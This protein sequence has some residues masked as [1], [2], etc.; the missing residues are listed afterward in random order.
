MSSVYTRTIWPPRW[1]GTN[2]INYWPSLLSL[3]CIRPWVLS[4]FL[5]LRGP[6]V[7]KKWRAS[8][9][10]AP[11]PCC[12]S[13]IRANFVGSLS[14][15]ENFSSIYFIPCRLLMLDLFVDT[16]FHFL[17]VFVSVWCNFTAFVR[18]KSDDVRVELTIR[19]NDLWEAWSH[20]CSWPIWRLS[21][22]LFLHTL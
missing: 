8:A 3:R 18:H 15:L 17:H 5:I 19:G 14:L 16:Y 11:F 12:A 13:G 22:L 10:K 7:A 20:S 4:L 21:F 6:A 2:T 1:P 9:P